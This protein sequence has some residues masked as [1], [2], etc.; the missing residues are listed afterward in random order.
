MGRSQC[1]L[2]CGCELLSAGTRGSRGWMSGTGNIDAFCPGLSMLLIRPTR[3]TYGFEIDITCN[4]DLMW[5]AWFVGGLRKVMSGLIDVFLPCFYT[6][7]PG[8]RRIA[9]NSG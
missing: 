6:P 8:V 2:V 7:Y 1:L 3:W 4:A 5:I 9:E